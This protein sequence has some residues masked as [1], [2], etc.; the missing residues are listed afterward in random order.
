L[1]KAISAA[2][3]L[4]A[5]LILPSR[6][7]AQDTAMPSRISDWSLGIGVGLF[8]PPPYFLGVFAPAGFISLERR[9]SETLALDLEL[10]G[11]YSRGHG[12]FEWHRGMARTAIGVRHFFMPEAAVRP[13]VY[14]HATLTVLHEDSSSFPEMTQLTYGPELGGGLEADLA[15]AVVLRLASPLVTLGR[16]HLWG[17]YEAEQWSY[18]VGIWPR[19]ELRIGF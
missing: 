10:G 2:F 12:D 3:V 4:S 6:A 15:E 19:A 1:I 8:P 7:S 5:L 18:D 13:S 16:S 17:D 14:A 9:L 11:H